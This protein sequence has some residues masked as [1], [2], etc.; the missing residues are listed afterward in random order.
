MFNI[1]LHKSKEI[2]TAAFSI[3]TMTEFINIRNFTS[4]FLKDATCYS[5]IDATFRIDDLNPIW[6]TEYYAG[7]KKQAQIFCTAFT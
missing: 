5:I 4:L 3:S 1:T 6:R 7:R 2:F